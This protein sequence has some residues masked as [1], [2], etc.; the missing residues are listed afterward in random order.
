MPV[1]DDLCRFDYNVLENVMKIM[2]KERLN[3]EECSMSEA[4]NAPNHVSS[5]FVVAKMAKHTDAPPTVFRS[6]S[7]NGIRS[8]QCAIWQAARATSAAP[9][10]FKEMYIDN[11][12]PGINYVDRGLGHN[13]PAEVA[14]EEAGKI[15]PT[16]KHFCLVSIGTGHRRAVKI[17][18]GSSSN[19]DADNMTTERSLFE[20]VKSFVP[21]M[22]SFMPGWKTATTFPCGVLALLK[23]AGAVSKLVTDSEQVHRRLRRASRT[24]DV[25][26]R[27]PYFRFNVER[28]VGDIG[29]EEW[30]R[31]EEIATHTMAYLHEYDVEENKMNCVECLVNPPEFKRTQK[32]II[33]L[34][35]D[36]RISE[37]VSR[38]Y[39]MVPYEKNVFFVGQDDL[40]DRI[41]DKLCDSKPHLHSSNCLI[42]NGWGGEN[43]DSSRI[44]AY[45]E[46][47]LSLR[48][49]D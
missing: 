3:S 5:T 24:T 26:K 38:P 22:V 11:P 6:Y 32:N 49:L 17:V 42:R 46:T 31:E 29:L 10:F 40:I 44:R 37:D 2:I 27:F 20:Q 30:K 13:N 23:M 18:D 21:S 39:F 25:D 36:A 41:F 47:K 15:W 28:D 43:T 14:L 16:A 8:S 1:G 19:N 33:T 9:S 45:P 34:I 7:G 48:L 35:V 12:R 4:A